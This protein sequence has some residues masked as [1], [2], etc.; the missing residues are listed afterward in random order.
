[1]CEHEDRPC[2]GA[3]CRCECMDCPD[4]SEEEDE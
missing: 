1:M 3:S 4:D 2:P